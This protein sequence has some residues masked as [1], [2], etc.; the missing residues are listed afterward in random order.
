MSEHTTTTESTAPPSPGELL[1]IAEAAALAAGELLLTGRPA[2]LKVA[3]TKSSSVDVVTE[4]DV[5]A[6]RLIVSTIRDRRPHDRILGEE[7]TSGQAAAGAADSPVRW[8]VDPLDGTVNY[9]YGRPTWAVSIGVEVEGVTVAGVVRVPARDE[10]FTAVLG[11]GARLGGAPISL[12]VAPPLG[13]ALVGTGFGYL[14]H[15]RTH[16]AAVLAQL[17]PGLRDVRREGAAAVDLCDLACGRLD[18]F[19]E[20][21]LQPWDFAA[22]ALIAREAGA[23]VTG[24]RSPEPSTEFLVAAAPELHGWLSAR[25]D[26]LGA[27]HDGDT[28]APGSAA[29]RG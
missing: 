27:W 10:T 6:E 9:L 25:L 8:V 17:I 4:M 12:G 2:D 24:H 11:G 28:E 14:R 15:R 13:E 19:Y 20:R 18:G 5:A 23:V 3:A 21:G 7:G 22:G 29:D 16:Q 26:E 1:A